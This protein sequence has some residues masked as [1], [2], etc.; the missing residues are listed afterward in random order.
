MP[1][2]RA[3][4]G[5]LRKNGQFFHRG[6]AKYTNVKKKLLKKVK[7]QLGLKRVN[8]RGT[9]TNGT[10][11]RGRGDYSF[12]NMA[13]AITRPFTDSTASVGMVNRGARS[14]GNWIGN[15]TGIPGAGTALG[16]A[17]SWLSRAFGF[18]DYTVRGNTFM[19]EG[20]NIAQFKSH[21]T[22]EFAHREFIMDI[23]STT[24]FANSAYP[25][26]P[27]N[28]TLFPWLSTIA[29]NFE[30]YEMLGLIFEFKS[31]SATA[32]GSV[33]TGLGTV[34]MATDYDVLDAPYLDKRAMEVS[35]FATSAAPFR[36]QIHPIECDPKQNVMKALFIQPGNNVSA[37]PDDPRFSAM[38]NFQ[39][40]TSGMQAVSV[41][42]E[43]WVSYHV[44]LSKPQL[45]GGG[46]G[47]STSLH[48][49]LSVPLGGIP[50]VDTLITN[51]PG[52]LTVKHVLGRL[53]ITCATAAGLGAYHISLGLRSNNPLGELLG[54]QNGGFGADLTGAT[55]LL[56]AS[57]ETGATTRSATWANVAS[58]AVNG[59]ANITYGGQSATWLVRMNSVGDT[60][61]LPIYTNVVNIIYH[62]Y[63]MTPYQTPSLAAERKAARYEG[64]E[65]DQIRQLVNKLKLDQ[66]RTAE[67]FAQLKDEI[68]DDE[69]GHFEVTTPTDQSSS[70]PS[71][72]CVPM[73]QVHRRAAQQFIGK[74]A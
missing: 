25:I 5:P 32:V 9:R 67:E 42:G 6:V 69:D 66:E 30:Q 29:K 14:L 70:S 41:I 64:S 33:N 35:E 23:S 2:Q 72:R 11:V 53:V 54:V 46:V 37:Y 74:N 58:S 71:T 55:F 73:I 20:N 49:R 38:G 62:D 27:G 63:Y 19:E 8:L 7:K 21:G 31:T 45:E 43:L 10:R 61:S 51:N 3:N 18:G 44:R 57:S 22:I 56:N 60:I 68:R 12:K 39:I 15:E 65:Y 1:G 13:Q 40:A 52:A 28:G 4:I 24:G 26:N 36:S 34:I 16:N 17:S 48:Q 50:T 47:A 59:L